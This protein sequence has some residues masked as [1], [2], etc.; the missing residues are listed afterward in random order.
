MLPVLRTTIIA[1]FLFSNLSF[2]KDYI[3]PKD[4]HLVGELTTFRIP[5]D[6]IKPLEFYAALFNTGLSN[7]L[8]ANRGIDPWLP[9]PGQELLIPQK[10]I[11]PDNL[12]EGIVIN[13]AEM[14][15]YYYHK[16]KRSVTVLPVGIGMVDGASP[17]N[18]VTYIRRKKSAPTWT[19]TVHERQDYLKEGIRLPAIVPAGPDNPMGNYALYIGNQYAIHGTNAN[20]GIGLRV[21]HGCI[22]LRNDDIKYLFDN[23]PTGTRV[24]FIN[25]PVKISKEN[26]GSIWIEVHQPLSHSEADLQSEKDLP[27]PFSIELLS[28][29]QKGVVDN[30]KV[31]LAIT[32]RSGIPLRIDINNN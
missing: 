23:V 18:W 13:N 28:L 31:D 21:S 30:K 9:A 4:G 8:E 3:L 24:Q 17:D 6:N 11:L 14:R 10:L 20:F 2:G 16:D 32:E 15:L 5:N 1:C 29:I 22:R 27:L 25:Q 12:E 19:P 7:L 26:D